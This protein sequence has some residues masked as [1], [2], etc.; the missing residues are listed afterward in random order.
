MHNR[1]RQQLHYISDIFEDR[2]F[3]SSN[4]SFMHRFLFIAFTI[5]AAS[6]FAQSPAKVSEYKKVFTTYPFS[7]PSPIALTNNVYPYF[8]YDGFT[9]KPV[10]KEWKVIELQNDFISLM[11][12]PEIGGKIWSATDKKTG[13]PFI[14]YNH[15]VKFRD[16]AMRGPWTSGGLEANYGIIGHTPNCATPVDYITTQNEDGSVSCFI[17]VLDLLTRSNW[18]IEIN[19]PKDKA[20]F[21]TRSFWYSN[22][23]I[24]VPYYHWM[25]LGVRAKGNLEFIF[26]GTNYIGHNGEYSDWPVN[27]SNGKKI[28]FYEQNDFGGPKSYHVTGK[29]TNFFGVYYHND[30]D[31]MVRYGNYDDKAGK[32]IWIWGLSRQGMIWEKMLT[33]TDGQ[34]VEIQSGRLFNQNA[35]Q[36]SYTPF[37]HVSFSPYGSDTWKE[38]WFP[39][40]ETRGIVEASPYGALNTLYE[41]GWLKL[42]FSA[43]QAIDDSLVVQTGGRNVYSKKIRLQPLQ[44]FTDSVKAAP[45]PQELLITLGKNKLQYNSN[46]NHNVISRPLATIDSFKWNTAYGLYIE[47]REL[48]DQ[49]MYAEAEIKLKASLEKDPA[50]V[51]ALLQS[52]ILQYRNLQY[53]NALQNIRQCLQFDAHDGETNYYYGL[54]NEKLGNTTDAIDGFSL[55]TLS[56]AYK[57][58]AFTGLTRLFTAAGNYDRAAGYAD[59]ATAYNNTNIN[60]YLLKAVALRK[61]GE[62]GEAKKVLDEILRV[63][64]LNHFARYEQYLLQPGESLNTAFSSLIRNELPG[65]T[66]TEMAIWYYNIACR[67]EAKDL[68]ERMAPNPESVCW[69]AFLND[70]PAKLTGV[71]AELA[72]PFRAETAMVLETLLQKQ[73][74]WL[75]KYQLALIYRDRNRL[76]EAGDLLRSCKNEP[77]FAPFYVVRSQV[78]N[79]DSAQVL[80]D[81]QKAIQLDASGWRYQKLQAEYYI[82]HSRPEKALAVA[83]AFY[84]KHPD[85][86]IMGMLY[87]KTLLLNKKYA[88]TDKLLT[89]LQIIPFEGA[90]DGR[91]LYRE[92]KLMQAVAALKQKKAGVAKK[93]IQ[94]AALWPENLGVGKPYDADIDTR[95]EDW[96]LYLTESK[97][98]GAAAKSLLQKII[99]FTPAT[100]NT[101]NNFLPSNALITALAISN[102][103]GKE[104]ANNWLEQQASAFPAYKDVFDWS[105]KVLDGENITIVPDSKRDSNLTI[106]TAMQRAGLL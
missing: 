90:T 35:T 50:F 27:K 26:P 58:V 23:S 93:F 13:K 5:I 34:Y 87:A 39:V 25:N 65:E 36:S 12:L 77:G 43:V 98:E 47:G 99:R 30:K 15:A 3:T 31:G 38:Y 94:Q 20:Y 32:K 69:L 56:E 67:E 86:L 74:D 106:L 2:F 49:K 9:D 75:L 103:N 84:Q 62:P 95:L 91:M 101:I 8:R 44:T 53:K 83:T 72:F 42:Y 22:S 54:V 68:F 16:I 29:L 41:D 76:A 73:N 14:Y 21:T 52:A 92:A 18:R 40:L 45:D 105:R 6:A 97:K 66:Y 4:R 81:L 60:A 96:M 17:G 63:D 59:K 55:A 104:Q 85:H 71:S 24:P 102:A 46:P 37:K 79:K 57:S 11:I 51:P 10:N 80:A 78:I 48:Y 19:L 33:D 28:N 88:E 89:G 82:E 7:D 64:P 61:L 70:Q 1:L 100:E